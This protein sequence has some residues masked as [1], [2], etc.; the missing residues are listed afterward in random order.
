MKVHY[1]KSKANNLL[2]HKITPSTSKRS[3]TLDLLRFLAVVFVFFGHYTDTFNYTYQIVPENLKYMLFSKYATT[4]LTLFFMISGYVVTMTSV[5]RNIQDFVITRLSRLYP[6]YWISCIVAFILPHLFYQNRSYLAEVS[7]T[8]FFVNLTM[9]PSVFLVQMMNPVF[10]TLLIELVFYIFISIIIIFKLWNNIVA[11]LCFMLSI[12][13]VTLF[14]PT[15]PLH[16]AVLPFLAGMVFY[17]ISAQTLPRRTV[18][19]LLAATYIIALAS[20][21]AQ[22][23]QMESFYKGAV[24]INPWILKVITSLYY[25]VFLLISLKVLHIP[26]RRI[27]QVLGELAYPLYLFHVYFLCFY[28]YFSKKIQ[29]DVLLFGILFGTIITSWLINIFLEKPLSNLAA[30]CLRKLCGEQEKN[31]RKAII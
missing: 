7:L 1:G 29:P 13:I 28:W 14:T 4:A 19:L 18:Y 12:C 27:Y 26:G 25:L 24:V 20:T 2:M 15:F 8:T 17:L 31:T 3:G 10:H 21:T 6:L 22:K 30:R 9:I 5:K 23:E 16:I 11:V